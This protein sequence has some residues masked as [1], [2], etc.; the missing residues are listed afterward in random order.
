MNAKW[1]RRFLGLAAHIAT[2]SKDPSSQVGAVIVRPDRT[3]ASA[4]FNGFPRGMRDDPELYEDRGSKYSRV[5]H[6]E[7]NAIVHATEKLRGF[8]LY[9]WPY[10]P[11]DR[12][13]VII[14]QAGIE[15][16]VAPIGLWAYHERH[17]AP[18]KQGMNYLREGGIVLTFMPAEPLSDPFATRPLPDLDNPGGAT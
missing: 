6:A 4:G 18:L 17:R 9:T 14:I 1:D 16:V 12:C 11:C 2:W 10:V 3:I 8:T 13:A 7:M 15:R 5:I